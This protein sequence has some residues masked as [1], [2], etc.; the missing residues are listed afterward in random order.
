M[1]A[2]L[3]PNSTNLASEAAERFPCPHPPAGM[4]WSSKVTLI[5]FIAGEHRWGTRALPAAPKKE[6]LLRILR[7]CQ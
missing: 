2:T 3:Q 7:H 6:E 5:L 4:Q 1:D